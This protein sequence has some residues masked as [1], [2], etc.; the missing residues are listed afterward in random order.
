MKTFTNFEIFVM[1]FLYGAYE[2]SNFF[3][4]SDNGLSGCGEVVGADSTKWGH[5][6]VLGVQL[7]RLKYL[8]KI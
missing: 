8:K 6:G 3:K 4:S 1:P 7:V 2:E 5:L